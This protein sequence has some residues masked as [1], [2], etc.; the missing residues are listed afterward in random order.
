MLAERGVEGARALLEERAR[1]DPRLRERI[2]ELRERL[3]RQ[4]ARRIGRVLDEYGQRVVQLESVSRAERER[5]EA[6]LARLEERRREARSVDFRHLTDASWLPDVTSALLL[7]DASWNQPERRSIWQR[8]RAFFAWI[9]QGLRRLFGRE[10][11]HQRLKETGRPMTFAA[12]SGG[13]RSLGESELGE[14][15]ARLSP[16]Q[17]TELRENMDRQV[18]AQERDLR[19]AAEEKRRAAEAQQRALEA[20]REEARRHSESDAESRLKDA[21]SRRLNRELTER[22]LATEKDGELSVTYGL[23]ERFAR[24]V[25]DEETRSLPRDV[26]MSFQGSASTGVYE[27]ARL[28]QPEEVAHLDLP[29]SMV[30]AR[31]EGAKHLEE[32]TSFIYREITSERVHVVLLLDKSGSMSEAEKLPAAKKALL[33]LYVAIRRRHPDAAID[34]IAFDNEVRLLDLLELWEC[35]PGSFTN[36]AEALHAAHYLLRSSRASRREVFLITDGLPESY[37]DIDGRVKSGQLDSAMEHA[38]VRAQEL[39]TVTP[40]KF[41]M[42]LLKSEHPEYEVAARRIAQT[43]GGSLVV[44]EPQKLGVELLIRWAGG[45]ETVH[46]APAS[47][48]TPGPTVVPSPRGKRRKADRRMGG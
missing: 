46:R 24:L 3:R 23:I 43:V 20:E 44:T 25:L 8:I 48:T 17:Q 29:S 10:R 35:P 30:Q 28:R 27:K 32:G 47:P 5:L 18:Q 37:T 39:S 42:I 4:A 21:V 33:A 31:L 45:T 34:V 14:V 38:V 9:L 13:G 40:L 6:Q 19:R 7:P 22:G 36:T 1:T 16:R 2:E 15:L 26:R 11:S 12:L 41:T